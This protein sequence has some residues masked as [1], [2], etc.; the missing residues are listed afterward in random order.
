[1]ALPRPRRGQGGVTSAQPMAKCTN[2]HMDIYPHGWA[3]PDHV[4]VRLGCAPERKRPMR[5]L[6]LAGDPIPIAAEF[7]QIADM[8]RSHVAHAHAVGG[9]EPVGGSGP[10]PQARKAKRTKQEAK[11]RSRF[12]SMIAI[13]QIVL[14]ASSIV[15]FD[16][17]RNP[18]AAAVTPRSGIHIDGVLLFQ[19]VLYICKTIDINEPKAAINNPTI[20]HLR[21]RLRF[22]VSYL[23]RNSSSAI[24]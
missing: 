20:V 12:M 5:S 9:G 14:L 1:M 7:R 19:N 6:P 23:T 15:G 11:R 17:A 18:H 24:G 4:S 8:V 2:T 21:L 10:P 22:R 3:K 13:D 16:R